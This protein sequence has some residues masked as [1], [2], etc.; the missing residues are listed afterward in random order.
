MMRRHSGGGGFWLCL[1]LNLLLNLEWSIPA[2][3]C[4][5]LHFWLGLSLWWF[6][7]ALALWV[8]RIL[9]GMWFVGWA[10]RC[11]AEK[12]P[13]KENKN[14]YSVKGKDGGQTFQKKISRKYSKIHLFSEVDWKT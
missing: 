2:W 1:L 12:D 11:G 14:P 7:G 4:L 6:A 10:A 9:L 3:I 5:A 8:G 13:P